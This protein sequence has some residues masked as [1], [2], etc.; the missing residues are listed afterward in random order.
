[1][2]V[3]NNN[4]ENLKDINGINNSDAE[5]DVQ[6]AELKTVDVNEAGNASDEKHH[7]HH[8]HH[9]SSSSEHH[10]HHHHHKSSK[11]QKWY[12]DRKL[13]II[14]VAV[15]LAFAIVFGI[16]AV[17]KRNSVKVDDTNR[18]SYNIVDQDVFFNGNRIKNI[19]VRFGTYNEAITSEYA[20]Y[21]FSPAD[22]FHASYNGPYTATVEYRDAQTE[23]YYFTISGIAQPIELT[24]ENGMIKIAV[25]KS[26]RVNFLYY[27]YGQ[28]LGDPYARYM[29]LDANTIEVPALGN[30]VHT[31]RINATTSV[32]E[33]GTSTYYVGI[34]VSSCKQPVVL[35]KDD[36]I[37]LYAYGFDITSVSYAKG[38]YDTWDEMKNVDGIFYTSCN[39]SLPRSDFEHG[40]YTFCFKSGATDYI[41]QE[42][43]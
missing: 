10:H 11:K 2:T 25:N 39:T 31:F 26:Y 37:G 32:G 12:K 16:R 6:L 29:S 13:I 7:H 20:D 34:D 19:Y 40:V 38:V 15:V 36:F 28:S 3:E 42:K 35:V 14:A 9:H 8:H 41:V 43:L 17:A 24:E 23:N 21:V 33:V 27:I 1:M 4:K 22:C 30:G 18:F 5:K